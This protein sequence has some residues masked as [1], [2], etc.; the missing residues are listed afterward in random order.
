MLEMSDKRLSDARIVGKVYATF[1]A[2]FAVVAAA[3]V[4]VA[5]AAGSVIT[6]SFAVAGGWS[7]S[8]RWTDS[9]F[10][11]VCALPD[12]PIRVAIE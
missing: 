2:G 11:L 4:G 8:S 12:G 7:D 6:G 3:A 9:E 5:A 1:E 10:G